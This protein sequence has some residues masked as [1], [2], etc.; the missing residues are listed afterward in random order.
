MDPWFTPLKIGSL[1]F[2]MLTI[3]EEAGIEVI[4]VYY[5]EKS[6]SEMSFPGHDEFENFHKERVKKEEFD[7]EIFRTGIINAKLKYDDLN[8]FFIYAGN[9]YRW[10][11]RITSLKSLFRLE[12]TDLKIISYRIFVT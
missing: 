2:N 9:Y 3:D 7:F 11:Q 10:N 8:P 4:G 1:L 5:L 12:S 6:F